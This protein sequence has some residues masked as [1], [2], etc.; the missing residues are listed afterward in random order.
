MKAPEAKTVSEWLGDLPRGQVKKL[1]KQIDADRNRIQLYYP[2]TGPLSRHHYKKHMRCFAAGAHHEIM[3]ECPKDCDGSP[4]RERLFLAGNRVGKTEGV[5]A[6]EVTCHLTGIYPEW[7]PGRRFDHG[8]RCWAAGDTSKTVRDIIQDKLLGPK[9]RW[10]TGMIPAASILG[11]PRR[12]HGIADAVEIL[13]IQHSSGEASTLVLKSYD[14]RRKAFQGTGQD[15]IWLDEE[16]PLDIYSECLLR[17]MTTD[18]II[19]LTF[20]PLLGL[21]DVVLAFLDLDEPEDD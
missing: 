4:H 14:Q 20:T 10:G 1:A 7:W 2:E 18:G 13:Y 5:G 9:G 12:R 8:V 11:E 6:Y 17:T 3:A 16:P 15:V 21:S 19:L